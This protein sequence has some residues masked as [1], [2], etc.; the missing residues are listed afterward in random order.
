[1][2]RFSN[3]TTNFLLLQTALMAF[4]TG[5]CLYA[6]GLR[7]FL[8]SKAIL[9][10]SSLV[11]SIISL[12]GGLLFGLGISLV[13]LFLLGTVLIWGTFVSSTEILSVQEIVIW[14]IAIVASS[15]ISGALHHWA[16]DTVEENRFMNSKFDQLVTIDETTGFDNKKRF[17][18]E[19]EEEFKRSVR[20]GTPF[21]LLFIQLKY[22]NEFKRL[23]G[24][25][26]ATHLVKTLSDVLW[27]QTRISDRK[28]RI[29][30][31][32][33]AVILFNTGEENVHHVLNKIE[34][35]VRH[36]KLAN[37]KKEVT[38]TLSFGTSSFSSDYTDYSELIRHASHDLEHYTQ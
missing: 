10:A 36:H 33:F 19:M 25:K 35:L 26:E 1:M 13:A 18:V 8:P 20:T 14:M 34:Q 38:I 5:L 9:V 32:L 22:F 37:G 6:A 11:I 3:K 15:V 16:S 4:F 17:H 23:Y 29:E 12:Y 28:F 2:R 7:T 21:S 24:G 31:D 27:K 30:D